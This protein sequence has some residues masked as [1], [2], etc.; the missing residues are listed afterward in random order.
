MPDQKSS[1][2]QTPNQDVAEKLGSFDF[3]SFATRV[4]QVQGLPTTDNLQIDEIS[5]ALSAALDVLAHE[6]PLWRVVLELET[7]K[8]TRPPRPGA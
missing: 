1:Q 7:R 4:S 5:E 3:T 8:A 6:V 2:D